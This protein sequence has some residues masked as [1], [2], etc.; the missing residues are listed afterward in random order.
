MPY[1]PGSIEAVVVRFLEV[2]LDRRVVLVVL[3]R[4]IAGP[5]AGRREHL[6]HEQAIGGRGRRQDVD[7]LARGIAAAPHLEA[8]VRRT[9]HPRLESR[10]GR[11]PA[12]GNLGET[13]RANLERRLWRQV[14]GV[15]IVREHIAARPEADALRAAG[16]PRDRRKSAEEHETDFVVAGAAGP[17]IASRDL[18]H[19][20]A[21]A[22]PACASGRECEQFPTVLSQGAAV[23]MSFGSALAP[24]KLRRSRH[25]GCA[26]AIDA[27]S[28]R[29]PLFC[30]CVAAIATR[31][32]ATPS[33]TVIGGWRS[34][35]T[36][37]REILELR[38]V[39]LAEPF[40]EKRHRIVGDL[41]FGHDHQ[42]RLAEIADRSVPL[43]PSSSALMS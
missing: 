37:L 10:R 18:A 40:H 13:R 34:S 23:Q 30:A 41:A 8:A 5:V 16:R 7:D 32:A 27:S 2:G 42:R 21:D 14:E 15:G 9:D 25:A 38:G 3:V 26:S 20:E 4:R 17:H 11:R 22:V 29:G 36:L 1:P 19:R 43:V 33:S 6:A 12:F 39:G 31:S 24:V 35:S 28:T